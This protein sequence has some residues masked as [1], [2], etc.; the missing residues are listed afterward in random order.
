MES[1]AAV[2]A[3]APIVLSA[4]A[5]KF[6]VAVFPSVEVGGDDGGGMFSSSLEPFKAEH[7]ED[8]IVDGK[9]LINQFGH[10]LE[11]FFIHH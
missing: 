10:L 9:C 8:V 7:S 1:D 5:D 11:L 6:I 2:A 4:T 3:A